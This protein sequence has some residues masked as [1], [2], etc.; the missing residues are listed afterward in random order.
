MELKS[1]SKSENVKL[2]FNYSLITNMRFTKKQNFQK[3]ISK[4]N[5]KNENMEIHR[6]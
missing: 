2:F 3:A 1:H 4:I 6:F 5:K